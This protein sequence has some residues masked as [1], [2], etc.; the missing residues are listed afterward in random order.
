MSS[1]HNNVSLDDGTTTE[2]GS[3]CLQKDHCLPWEF[4]EAGVQGSS[5][6]WLSVLQ[7]GNIFNVMKIEG[8]AAVEISRYH[9]R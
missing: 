8:E 6:T 2:Q 5:T 1:S 3:V 4:T 7:I 9:K